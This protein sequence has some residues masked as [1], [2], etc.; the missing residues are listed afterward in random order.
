MTLLSIFLAGCALAFLILTLLVLIVAS[1]YPKGCC[2]DAAYSI[3]WMV[4]RPFNRHVHEWQDYPRTAPVEAFLCG[5]RCKC[6]AVR[7]YDGPAYGW[8]VLD[9]GKD[10]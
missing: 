8:V 4:V 9:E 5:Q 10:T 6:G 3:I 7:R 2:A 1:V